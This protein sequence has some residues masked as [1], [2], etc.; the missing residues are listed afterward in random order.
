MGLE[1]YFRRQAVR[2]W[3][4][5]SATARLVRGALD[6]IFGFVPDA[7]KQW[8]DGALAKDGLWVSSVYYRTPPLTSW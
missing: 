8:T 4:L 7:L 1:S 3:G 6:L 5:G 2:A